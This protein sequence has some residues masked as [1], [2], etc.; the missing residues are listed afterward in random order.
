[1]LKLSRSEIEADI[2]EFSAILNQEFIPDQCL[3]CGAKGYKNE[4]GS[5]SI[6][7]NFNCS[8]TAE[9]LLNS[10]KSD[11]AFLNRARLYAKFEE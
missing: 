5:G 1:M 8:K 6:R 7:H 11:L 10:R 2:A 3:G 9:R 4:N